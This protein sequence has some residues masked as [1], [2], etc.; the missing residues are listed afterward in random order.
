MHAGLGDGYR[1]ENGIG[2]ENGRLYPVDYC[3]PARVV[4][5]GWKQSASKEKPF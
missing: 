2:L 4:E 1:P 3:S 5:I